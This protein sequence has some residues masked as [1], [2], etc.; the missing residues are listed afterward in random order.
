MGIFDF[1]GGVERRDRGGKGGREGEGIEGEVGM[2]LGR[3]SGCLIKTV[4]FISFHSHKYHSQRLISLSSS[5]C[6]C[7]SSR[8]SSAKK[9]NHIFINLT[10]PISTNSSNIS[11][12]LIHHP[13][14]VTH[15]SPRADLPVA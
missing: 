7:S 11:N 4:L 14:G 12:P 13:F 8:S 6:S 1:G 5:F 10:P 3:Q 9:I 15:L 2:Y